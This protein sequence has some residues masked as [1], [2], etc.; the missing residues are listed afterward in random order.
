MVN[1]LDLYALMLSKMSACRRDF[2]ENKYMS[3]LIKNDESQENDNEILD[4]FNRVIKKRFDSE[5]V[6]NY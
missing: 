1:K 2:D 4:N 3:F 5:L 6:Y